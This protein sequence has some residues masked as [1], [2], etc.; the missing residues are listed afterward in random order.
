MDGTVSTWP[1]TTSVRPVAVSIISSVGINL[2]E[3]DTT[4]AVGVTSGGMEI[5]AR[6][7][8]RSPA[9]R[10]RSVSLFSATDMLLPGGTIRVADFRTVPVESTN[11]TAAVQIAPTA[12]ASTPGFK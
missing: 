5:V 9:T 4:I 12:G 8:T 10:F 1:R 3:G 11:E 2:Q 6:I 7:S